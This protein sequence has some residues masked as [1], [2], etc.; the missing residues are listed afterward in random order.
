MT[1][2]AMLGAS[3][4]GKE[5]VM[6]DIQLPLV[7]HRML[8]RTGTVPLLGRATPPTLRFSAFGCFRAEVDE[9]EV[10]LPPITRTMLARLVLA[11]GGLVDADDLYRDAWPEPV[12]TIRREQRVGIHKRVAE[13]RRLLAPRHPA[14][15]RNLLLTE[16]SARTGYRL[17]LDSEQVDVHQFEDLIFRAAATRDTVAAGLLAQAL[18]L[19][20]ETPL[21]G[22]PDKPFVRDGVTRLI[23]LRDRAC[24]EL[25]AVLRGLNRWREAVAVFDQLRSSQP[26]DIELRQLIDQLH[27]GG[28]GPIPRP[29][30]D[31]AW[32]LVWNVPLR[33]PDLVPRTALVTRVRER[34]EDGPVVVTGL[35]GTGKTRLAVEYA[36]QHANQYQAV[37]W[38][39]AREPERLE[40]QVATLAGT[41]DGLR[42]FLRGLAD[43]GALLVFDGA[44]EPVRLRPWLPD[45]GHVLITSRNPHWAET[46]TPVVLD[47]FTRAESLRL[48]ASR[49]PGLDHDSADR[50]AQALGDLPLAL[51]QAAQ[52]LASDGMTAGD[53]LAELNRRPAAL[54]GRGR[55]VSYPDPLVEALRSAADQLRATEPEALELLLS[56]LQLGRDRLSFKAIPA[57][58]DVAPEER[59]RWLG[60]VGRSGL[61][62]VVAGEVHLHPLARAVLLDLLKPVAPVRRD[63]VR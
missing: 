63:R 12:P 57:I 21:L 56:C 46:A 16:R 33:V 22:L 7:A 25:A 13:I 60:L 35:L 50:L 30:D 34:L 23:E 62:R 44:P 54:A 3:L 6:N 48:L 61:A 38:F 26:A 49:L 20:T 24:R 5:D 37:C 11:R 9:A 41:D 52:L 58:G 47:G 17:V 53:Y 42:A 59:Q 27:D 14:S 31:D 1:R 55:V 10:P 8:G 18:A 45:A 4:T 39:D 36:Q 28:D 29:A 51:A 40:A 32:P 19:W 43:R 2:P 15:G